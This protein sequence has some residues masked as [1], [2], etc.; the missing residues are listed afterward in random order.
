MQSLCPVGPIFVLP[1]RWFLLI[2][3]SS[4]IGLYLPISLR[5]LFYFFFIEKWAFCIS[6]LC[7]NSGNH[8]LPSLQALP[9]LLGV[10]LCWSLFWV[11]FVT[12]VFFALCAA[13]LSV[14]RAGW[15][16]SDVSLHDCNQKN[17]PVFAK[18]LCVHV[19]V[20]QSLSCVWLFVTP[21]TAARQASLSST[22]SWSWLTP[23][24]HWVGDA[25]Q[26]SHCLLPPS[27]P[28]FSFSQHQGLFQWV[29]SAS[30]GQSIGP[31]ASTLI[32]PMNIQGWFP[33]GLTVC[34]SRP[35]Q[36]HPGD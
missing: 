4:C 16:A 29:N 15:S 22:V 2:A 32:L 10:V 27:P 23:H 5:A 25:I 33:L 18:G 9:L 36:N 14:L 20:V 31:S 35:V 30:G 3:F 12:F 17:V 6:L 26:P 1:Q 13:I 34:L 21:W 24:V 11:N 28:A 7:H 19:V 8:I